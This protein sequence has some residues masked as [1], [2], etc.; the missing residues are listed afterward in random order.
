MYSVVGSVILDY[1]LYFPVCTAHHLW[2]EVCLFEQ[3]PTYNLPGVW[4]C[5][6]GRALRVQSLLP[7]TNK[8]DMYTIAM[9]WIH[10]RNSV[11]AG[12]P[13]QI[14][15][16]C[17]SDGPVQMDSKWTNLLYTRDNNMSLILLIVSACYYVVSDLLFVFTVKATWVKRIWIIKVLRHVT[18]HRWAYLHNYSYIVTT[19]QSVLIPLATCHISE[20]YSPT[21]VFQMARCTHWA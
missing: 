8:N 7:S 6:C 19:Q 12:L 11:I 3:A 21:N 5:I 1:P 18:H 10:G 16:L 15:C 9:H 4:S 20:R 2:A 17:M 14:V 13:L